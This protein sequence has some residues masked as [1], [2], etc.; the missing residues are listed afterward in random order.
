MYVAL[1][2]CALLARSR[3][4]PFANVLLLL[5]NGAGLRGLSASYFC[6]AASQSTWSIQ[7]MYRLG[8]LRWTSGEQGY[9]AVLQ[10]MA[11]AGANA[12]VVIPFM[13]SQ[14][15]KSAFQIGALVGCLSYVIQ[16]LSWLPSGASRLRT[17]CQVPNERFL[18]IPETEMSVCQ[19]RLGTNIWKAQH[20]ALSTVAQYALG[21]FLLNSLP[22]ACIHS[23]RAMIIKQ[24]VTVTTCVSPCPALP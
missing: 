3:A 1:V 12:A 6:F 14:G 21:I 5:R 13:K 11:T 24:G 20:D 17:A 22:S 23:M 15:N 18:S 7:S 9:F 19:D 4:N 16:G 10:Q 2:R 8:P